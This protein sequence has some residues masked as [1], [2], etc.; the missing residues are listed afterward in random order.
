MKVYIVTD[1]CYSDYSIQK[2]FSNKPAAEE[3][4]K[5]HNIKNEVEEYEL[6]DSSFADE[7]GERAVLIRVQGTVYLG[8]VEDITYEIRPNIIYEQYIRRGVGIRPI[9]NKPRVF[10]IYLYHYI[11]ADKW[12]EEKYKNKLTKA[13]Y[14]YAAMA[15]SMFAE[16]A[17]V[18]M[19]NSTLRNS[20]IEEN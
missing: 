7:T 4:K 16:G 5:W 14:D 6:F 3:Y 15:R 13:L 17:T 2:V 9:I 20:D 10:I 19:I 11:P 12:D 8:A 18:D 1:G